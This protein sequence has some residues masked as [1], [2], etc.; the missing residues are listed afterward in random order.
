MRTRSLRFRLLAAAAI[1]ISVALIIA[2]FGLVALFGH[3]VERQLDLELEGFL[4]ELV[5]H[6]EPDESGDIR[7]TRE[8]SDPRFEKPLGGLYWQIQDTRHRTLIRSR[9]LWDGM[10]ELPHDELTPGKV[11]RHELPGPSGQSLLVREQ[12]IILL[13]GSDRIRVRV[14]VAIDHS[15]L[16]AA[17]KAFSHDLLPY[18]A[19][20]A[21]ALILATWLQVRTGLSPLYCIRRG[22][23]EIR[24]GDSDRLST[25][26]P[27]E[28]QPLAE[29]I[30]ELLASRERA[31]ESARAWTADLAHGLK[32]P[33]TALS[34]DAENLRTRGQHE[35]AD[36]L[37]QLAQDM[38]QRVDRELIRAR[39]I[40]ESPTQPGHSNVVENINALI[41]TLQRTPDG[42]NVIWAVDG[43]QSLEVRIPANDLT[44]LLGNLL[45]NAMKWCRTRV[46]ISLYV[47]TSCKILIEDDGAGVPEPQR[48]QLVQR[49]LRLDQRSGGS[50]LGLAIARDIVEA[51]DSKMSFSV[52]NAGGLRVTLELPL[53]HK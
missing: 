47:N 11:H 36:N 33:L 9:S 25:V 43:P 52:A 53:Y 3:H 32:T 27:E 30:N 19:L 8:L 29:E 42:Q 31:V 5:G 51:Y 18:L 21:I 45:E 13:P 24:S 23:S 6:I 10:L 35:I 17:R 1:F 28:V 26:F 48:E 20:L 22:V 39:L 12:Q 15:N 41:K 14:A 50:G 38:R 16:V 34:T 37:E 40:N 4:T 49:G 46:H 2:G 44:E 7:L